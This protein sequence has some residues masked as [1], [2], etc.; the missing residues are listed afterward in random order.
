M[1]SGSGQGSTGSESHLET[2]LSAA[3]GET[4]AETA[5]RWECSPRCVAMRRLA[6][7]KWLGARNITHAVAL[8]YQRG[9]FHRQE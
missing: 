1:K 4:V 9:H 3:E 6:A 8:A 5:A 7:V 2:L